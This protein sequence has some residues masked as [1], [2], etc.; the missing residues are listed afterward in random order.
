MAR[1]QVAEI[2]GIGENVVAW[3]FASVGNQVNAVLATLDN[4]SLYAGLE[5]TLLF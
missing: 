2:L 3:S 4:A 1:R 5:S